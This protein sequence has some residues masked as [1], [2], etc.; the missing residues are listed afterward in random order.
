[1]RGT[2]RYMSD[3]TGTVS[4]EN[5]ML[6]LVTTHQRCTFT[7]VPTPPPIVSN[8]STAHAQGTGEWLVDS[9]LSGR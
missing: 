7:R 2:Y 3:L 5:S 4:L 6:G 9:L 8:A 1:M